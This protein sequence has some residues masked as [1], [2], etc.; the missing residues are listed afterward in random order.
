MN[1][2]GKTVVSDATPSTTVLG[3]GST[4]TAA[5]NLAVAKP[6][7]GRWLINVQLDGDTSGKE[8]SQVVFGKVTFGD[9]GVTVLSG[10]PTKTATVI[11][12]GSTQPV[13]LQVINTTGVGRTFEFSS[14]QPDITAVSAYIPAGASQLVSLALEPTAAVGTAVKGKLAVT[15]NTSDPSS[16]AQPTLATL[17]YKYTVEAPA[18][19]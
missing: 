13:Q 19:G 10:L 16:P 4:T 2:N 9:S 3:A 17:P 8:F 5:A 18:G 12:Q 7:A 14:N 6:K 11:P 15:T 1:P